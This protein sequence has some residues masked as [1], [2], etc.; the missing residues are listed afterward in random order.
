VSQIVD[1]YSARL[2]LPNEIA[3]GIPGANHKTM[4]R[5]KDVESQK[6]LPVWKAL[7]KLADSAVTDPAPCT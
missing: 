7:K 6:Y 2:G 3:V 1:K 5:F 4:C